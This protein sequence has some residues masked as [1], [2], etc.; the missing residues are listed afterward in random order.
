MLPSPV[1]T[2]ISQASGWQVANSLVKHCYLSEGLPHTPEYIR[3]LT[4]LPPLNVSSK[5]TERNTRQN[6]AITLSNIC[7]SLLTICH[8]LSQ[9][10]INCTTKKLNWPKSSLPCLLS[11][12]SS[13]EMLSKD[14]WVSEDTSKW[15]E[16]SEP[17]PHR[18]NLVLKHRSST[19]QKKTGCRTGHCMGTPSKV[20][21]SW[22]PFLNL[23][24]LLGDL[25]HSK[26]VIIGL[27]RQEGKLRRA[28]VHN[29]PRTTL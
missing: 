25:P 22:I 23:P 2:S 29:C 20:W 9:R 19:Y 21:Q 17:H 13:S 14:E 5:C 26:I 12:A 7:Q 6:L 1:K 15:Q 10:C 27:G 3:K 28:M 18:L 16:E 11:C 4:V 8:S 24:P